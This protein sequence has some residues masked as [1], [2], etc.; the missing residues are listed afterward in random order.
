ME[1]NVASK[2]MQ[3]LSK[4]IN[5]NIKKCLFHHLLEELLEA[6]WKCISP[7]AKFHIHLQVFYAWTYLNR[8]HPS[9]IHIY[10]TLDAK[11]FATLNLQ[12]ISIYVKFLPQ[13]S[14]KNCIF[15]RTGLAV[16]N[17]LAVASPDLWQIDHIH[18]HGQ[19]ILRWDEISESTC[20]AASNNII[21][22][23]NEDGI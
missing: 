6:V 10:F 18:S 5:N 12:C 19:D 14:G 22:F 1:K 3:N 17:L 2:C 23:P 21:S 13:P 16:F 4:C 8:F 15:M 9:S 20:P 7:I 11:H